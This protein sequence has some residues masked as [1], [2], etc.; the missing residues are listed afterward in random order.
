[1]QGPISS[2]LLETQN[3]TSPEREALVKIASLSLD[4]PLILFVMALTHTPLLWILPL[5]TEKDHDR[6]Q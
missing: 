5:L 4:K 3:G 2:V 1:M 6:N